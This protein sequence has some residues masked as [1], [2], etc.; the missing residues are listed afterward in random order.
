[1]SKSSSTM[2]SSRSTDNIALAALEGEN[3]W[4]CAIAEG[5]GT[6]K[7]VGVA[8]LEADTGRCVLSQASSCSVD[9]ANK[10]SELTILFNIDSDS[11]LTLR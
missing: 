2:T 10:D 11:L 7:E 5:R 6:G 1:M 3:A 8:L 4:I 9:E